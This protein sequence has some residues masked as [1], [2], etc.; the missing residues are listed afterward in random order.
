MWSSDPGFR[1]AASVRQTECALVAQ[2]EGFVVT[3]CGKYHLLL[4]LGEGATGVVHL[5]ASPGLG[6]FLKLAVL[7]VLRRE[8]VFEAGFRKAFLEEARITARL[9]HPNLVTVFEVI[10]PDGQ[11]AI[12]MEYLDGC[13]LSD[14][15]GE[16]IPRLPMDLHLFVLSEVLSGLHAAHEL[17]DLDG[18]PMGLVHRD[19][20]PHNV[21]LTFDGQAKVLDFGIAKAHR[22]S[23]KT[24]TGVLKGKIRYMA[25]EQMLGERLDRRADVFAVGAMLHEA[26]TGR[27]LWGD[28]PDG[29]VLRWL[30][31]AKVP[32]LP[33]AIDVD[34]SLRELRDAALASSPQDRI[35]TAALLRDGIEAYLGRRNRTALSAELGRFL[36]SHLG[37]HQ[38]RKQELIDERLRMIDAAEAPTKIARTI[39]LA[40][41]TPPLK[42]PVTAL[43]IGLQVSVVAL[44]AW[45]GFTFLVPG[46]GRI[47]HSVAVEPLPCPYHTKRC[48]EGCVSLD[49]PDYGCASDTC[50]SCVVPNATARCDTKGGCAIAICY[51][52]YEDCDGLADNGCEIDTRTDPDHCGGCDATCSPLPH[53]ERGCGDVCTIWR[54][55]HGFHDCNGQVEDGCEA[56]A[57][58]HGTRCEV[59]D[60]PCG[61]GERCEESTCRSVDP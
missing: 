56:K 26:L 49:R 32:E 42:R 2:H 40:P 37:E 5:A 34:P 12:V 18:T 14:I 16:G 8:L 27:P 41:R 47:S 7:K 6:G 54:C 10:E 58:D 50:L 53:A 51:Q 25:P 55:E 61:P 11:P 30:A 60:P 29:E 3:P 33:A 13:P 57:T 48:D 23:H 4:V 52:G 31:N 1:A 59:C 15:P 46:R 9:A 35:E 39:E 19:V 17:L 28:L 24:E 22:S 38:I 21:F 43:R 20:S 36:K 44:A 45:A